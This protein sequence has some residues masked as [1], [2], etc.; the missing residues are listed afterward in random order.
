MYIGERGESNARRERRNEREVG[1]GAGKRA[2]DRSGRSFARI[3][4]YERVAGVSRK[5]ER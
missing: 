4:S 3:S 2:V 5:P 1:N